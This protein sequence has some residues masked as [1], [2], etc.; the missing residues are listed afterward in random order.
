MDTPFIELLAHMDMLKE[1]ERNERFMNFLNL[2]YSNPF[3]D[4]QGRQDYIKEIRPDSQLLQAAS[5]GNEKLV[6][7]LDQ[8]RLLKQM[9]EQEAN[10]EKLKGG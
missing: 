8:L 3:S 9:Q 7:N 4:K 1:K 2:F 10:A 5:K 6:T